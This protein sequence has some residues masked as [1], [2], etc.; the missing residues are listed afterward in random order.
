MRKRTVI[1]VISDCTDPR[2]QKADIGDICRVLGKGTNQKDVDQKDV[3]CVTKTLQKEY[4]SYVDV[5]SGDGCVI[6][7]QLTHA[8]NARYER[9]HAQLVQWGLAS[10]T[11][12][13]ATF[14]GFFLGKF[15]G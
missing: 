15:F 7:K 6:V 11:V 1:R 4:R 8:E 3:D 2:D 12:I 9:R 14:L 5:V 10:A 13:V